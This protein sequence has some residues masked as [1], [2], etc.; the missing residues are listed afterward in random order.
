MSIP[1]RILNN[2]VY[3]MITII[4]QPLRIVI[5]PVCECYTQATGGSPAAAV[6][7]GHTS[8]V[9]LFPS[10]GKHGFRRGL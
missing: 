7:V 2:R 3:F 9:T 10:F 8:L 4:P 1:H 6:G 5:K